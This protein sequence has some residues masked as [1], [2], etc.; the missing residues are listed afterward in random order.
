M[1]R[2]GLSTASS[3]VLSSLLQRCAFQFIIPLSQ[4]TLT[5]AQF[6]NDS[7]LQNIHWAIATG[8]FGKRDVGRIEREF[9]EV[10]DWD[11]TVSE[12]E[13][14][15]L[16]PSIIALYPRVQYPTVAPSRPAR[17]PTF[18][19]DPI[20]YDSDDSGSSA[21]SSPRTPWGSEEKGQFV[22]CDPPKYFDFLH[23]RQSSHSQ[24]QWS[25][26]QKLIAALANEYYPVI[27][28]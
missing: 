2:N 3:S 8:V 24:S 25:Q 1:L 13:I 21:T 14:A 10:L 11:L 28:V 6:T 20:S 23:L 27:A 9:L 16:H 19:L 5:L 26:N 22:K 17:C 12:N 15:D 4:T 7:T 18:T